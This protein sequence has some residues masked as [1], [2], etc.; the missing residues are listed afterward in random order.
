MKLKEEVKE[1]EG[2][3]RQKGS[4]GQTGC[5]DHKNRMWPLITQIAGMNQCLDSGQMWEAV[6]RSNMAN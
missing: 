4:R 1:L 3:Y 6:G 5:V 2:F